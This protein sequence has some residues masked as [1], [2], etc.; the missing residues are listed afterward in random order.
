MSIEDDF[1]KALKTI[2]DAKPIGCGDGAI[3]EG[4]I[5]WCGMGKWHSGLH[6][7]RCDGHLYEWSDAM[8]PA[9]VIAQ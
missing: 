7:A 8:P 3:I 6:S 9:E 4:V 1:L 5:V 2:R